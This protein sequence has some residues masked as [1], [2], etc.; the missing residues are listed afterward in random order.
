MNEPSQRIVST[1]WWFIGGTALSLFAVVLAWLLTGACTHTPNG[2]PIWIH[3]LI[4]FSY[5]QFNLFAIWLSAR[6]YGHN[7]VPIRWS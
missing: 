2:F 5:M 3:A 1:K 4:F 6:F 7:G